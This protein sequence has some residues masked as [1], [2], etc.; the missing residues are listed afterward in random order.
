MKENKYF[1]NYEVEDLIKIAEELGD[2]TILPQQV[3]DVFVF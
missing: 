2:D 1:D 3:Q